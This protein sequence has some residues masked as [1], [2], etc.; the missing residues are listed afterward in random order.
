MVRRT[1]IR[2]TAGDSTIRRDRSPHPVMADSARNAALSF[3]NADEARLLGVISDL[4]DEDEA[5]AC[6]WRE[7]RVYVILVQRERRR[8][9]RSK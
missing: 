2:G 4:P 5:T 8:A 9:P 7:G 3:I 1:Y 6:A